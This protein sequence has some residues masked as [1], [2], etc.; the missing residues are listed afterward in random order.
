MITTP[1]LF[2]V[3]L[4]ARP[5]LATRNST[6]FVFGE[7]VA[8]LLGQRQ[9][10]FGARARLRL[11]AQLGAEVHIVDVHNTPFSRCI[12]ARLRNQAEPASILYA[13]DG[14][15]SRKLGLAS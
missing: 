4:S 3:T 13:M 15:L 2:F 7:L 1:H 5:S 12:Y 8:L 11:L 6:E 9:Q 10:L 14:V